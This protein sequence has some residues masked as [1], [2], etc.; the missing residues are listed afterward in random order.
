MMPNPET[1][2]PVSELQI[3]GVIGMSQDQESG[4]VFSDRCIAE[5]TTSYTL[6][7]GPPTGV[8]GQSLSSDWG[9]STYRRW[10]KHTLP[11]PSC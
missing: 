3:H 9:T 6:E 4:T 10:T 2:G 11:Y 8:L 5:V 7:L 1:A